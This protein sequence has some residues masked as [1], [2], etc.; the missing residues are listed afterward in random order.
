MQWSTKGELQT[1]MTLIEYKL[2][3]VAPLITDPPQSSS[4]TLSNC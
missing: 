1:P 2:D 4:K 3:E